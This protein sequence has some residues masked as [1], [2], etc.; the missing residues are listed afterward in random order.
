MML[1]LCHVVIM[2]CCHVYV[3]LSGCRDDVEVERLRSQDGEGPVE[4][5]D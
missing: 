1:S 5:H 4:H 3:M 2:S